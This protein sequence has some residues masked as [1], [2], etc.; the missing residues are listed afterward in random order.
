VTTC[1]VLA[2]GVAFAFVLY[3][4]AVAFL[5]SFFPDSAAALRAPQRRLLGLDAGALLLLATGLGFL[6]DRFGALLT[7]RFPALALLDPGSPS[8]IGS[9][10]PAVS[11]VAAALPAIF[12]RGAILAIL[13]LAIQ[14]LPKRWML[15]PLMLLAIC[16]AV[17]DDVRTPGEFALQYVVAFAA[18]AGALAFCLWC[19]R[20]NYLAYAV[21]L[22]VMA[23]H[24]ALAELFGNGN[25]ALQTQAWAVV[26]VMA[27]AIGWAIGP[28]L[29]R[30]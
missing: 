30:K 24:P 15:A 27:V 9:P 21:V 11:A 3:G 8:L 16:A 29:A 26:A 10:A 28:G 13:A 7:D 14:R 20:N 2:M 18:I 17:S 23:L 5:L 12:S 4:A 22:G 19:A 1:A 6:Y 25:A